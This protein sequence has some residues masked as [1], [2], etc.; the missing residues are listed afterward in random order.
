MGPFLAEEEVNTAL[1]FD[2]FASL[3]FPL[4]RSFLLDK[5]YHLNV[6]F[7]TIHLLIYSIFSI[8]AGENS[9]LLESYHRQQHDCTDMDDRIGQAAVNDSNFSDIPP[10]LQ[11]SSTG[12]SSS[13]ASSLAKTRKSPSL[14]ATGKWSKSV[15][16]TDVWQLNCNCTKLITTPRIR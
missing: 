9:S 15:H 10:P 7:H 13:S 16:Q 12:H 3:W 1:C 11:L 4:H 6:A 2:V 14:G 5:T 8:T